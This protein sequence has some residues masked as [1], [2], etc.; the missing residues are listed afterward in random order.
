ML[1]DEAAGCEGICSA[2]TEILAS[3]SC[4]WAGAGGGVRR[5]PRKSRPVACPSY[6]DL[7]DL[8]SEPLAPP[9]Q[10]RDLRRRLRH[11]RPRKPLEHFLYLSPQPVQGLLKFLLARQNDSNLIVAVLDRTVYDVQE[12][13]ARGSRG[14]DWDKSATAVFRILGK[15]DR[16]ARLTFREGVLPLLS[17]HR[18]CARRR[19]LRHRSRA[20]VRERETRNSSRGSGWPRRVST[21]P[22]LPHSGVRWSTAAPSLPSIATRPGVFGDVPHPPAPR[23]ARSVCETSDS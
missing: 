18:R 19:A 12:V 23:F 15:G 22:R 20:R 14:G 21:V 17:R 4:G 5:G 1:Q 10:H 11:F 8:H 6:L 3:R 9:P 16:P 13:W 2:M 7:L